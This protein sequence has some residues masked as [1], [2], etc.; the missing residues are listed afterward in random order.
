LNDL[1]FAFFFKLALILLGEWKNNKR[2]GKGVFTFANGDVYT[3]KFA[4]GLEDDDNATLKYGTG[5]LYTGSFRAGKRHGRG[6]YVHA[7]GDRFEGEYKDDQR[8]GEGILTR[9]SGEVQKGRWENGE[10]VG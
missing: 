4:E 10:F 1:A 3:G 7:N 6:T 9:A 8:N 2:H 5:D